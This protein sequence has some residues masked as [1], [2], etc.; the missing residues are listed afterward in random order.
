MDGVE[1]TDLNWIA[2][3]IA[4]VINIVLGFLWYSPKLPTGKIWMRETKMD[5]NHKP[6]A[7][8]MTVAMILMILGAFLMVFVF[9]HTFIAY[10]DAYDLDAAGDGYKLTMLDGVIGA[11]MTWIAFFVPVL[12]S[13]IAWEGKSWSLFFVQAGYYLVTLLVVGVVYAGMIPA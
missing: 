4:I 13:G 6:T 1:L 11:V 12:W 5:P 10:R 7:K 2:I 3:G 8:Q 9:Q